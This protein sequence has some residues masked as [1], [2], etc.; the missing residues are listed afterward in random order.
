MARPNSEHPT[1]AELDAIRETASKS[2][3]VIDII[4]FGNAIDLDLANLVAAHGG[5]VAKVTDQEL[6][7]VIEEDKSVLTSLQ[8]W[9]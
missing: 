1:P 2:T 3:A 9:R 8:K 5:E 6:K 7:R 4:A